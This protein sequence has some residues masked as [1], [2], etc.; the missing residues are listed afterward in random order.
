MKVTKKGPESSVIKAKTTQRATD[1]PRTLKWWLEKDSDKAANQLVATAAYLKQTQ[2][3]RYRQTAIYARLYGNMSLFN[4]IGSNITKMD[5]SKGL[6]ADRPTRNVIQSSIDTL[7]SRLTQSRPAPVFLT[8]NG[9]YKERNL[10]KKLN[11]FILGEF[12][13]TKAYDKAEQVLRDGMITGTGAMLVYE[14][15][16]KVALERVLNTELLVDSNEAMY[17]EPRQ[18]YRMKLVDRGVL[19]STFGKTAEDKAKV[20]NAEGAYPDASADSTET[21][22]DMVIVVESWRLPSGPDA[23]DGRHMIACST[24]CLFEEPYEKEKFPIVFFHYAPRMLGFWAQGIAERLMGTQLDINSLLYQISKA[25]KLVGVPRVF[26]ESGSKVVNTSHN[27]EIGVIVKYTGVKPE[28]EVA[29]CVPLEMYQQLD[30][31]VEYAYQQEGVS[32]MQASSQKPQG[33]NSGAAIRSYDDISTDRFASVSRRYDNLFI[34]L[35]Y[36]IVDK[37]RDIAIRDGKYQTVYPDKK[38]GTKCIDLP[39][40]SLL[41]DPFVIQC[42]SMSS[43]PRDPAGRKQT[44]T[45][46]VQSGMITLREG[47]RLLDYPDLGQMDTLA[48]AQEE[49][50]FMILDE[51]VEEGKYTPADP[52]MD[53]ALAN[54]LVVQY[55]NLY[56]PRKLEEKRAQMLRTFHKQINDLI[57]AGQ[58]PPPG[59]AVPGQATPQALPEPLPTNPMVPNAI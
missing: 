32:Q 1:N 27:N 46:M 3:Y 2:S 7:V 24:G 48:N 16:G 10:A 44:V 37:A 11:N 55:Y 23:G 20:V 45:E 4:F 53:L 29:P 59:A 31:M 8:D 18:L 22:A 47:R 17:G 5:Q 14:E 58:Q 50:I 56:V 54:E 13:Q 19:M 39:K 40:A 9:D 57:T 41:Q 12:Y 34:D 43:L 42:F 21:V 38:N 35:A 26:Q 28:Y 52:F 6:P 51:I 15:N 25:I 33:L 36:L 30:R 49:R